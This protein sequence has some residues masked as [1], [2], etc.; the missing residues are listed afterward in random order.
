MRI[1]VRTP[2][3]GFDKARRLAIRLPVESLEPESRFPYFDSASGLHVDLGISRF[4]A[5][6]TQLALRIGAIAP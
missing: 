1:S 5:S 4:S 2:L 6:L 3:S